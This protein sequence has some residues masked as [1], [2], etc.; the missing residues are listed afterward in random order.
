M[1][2]TIWLKSYLWFVLLLPK[3]LIIWLSNLS[4]L[5]VPD[6]GCSRNVSCTLNLTSTFLILFF[7]TFPLYWCVAAWD[8]WGNSI[9]GHMRLTYVSGNSITGQMW[10][11]YVRGSPITG[12]MWITYVWG[13][14]IT[15]HIWLTYVRGNPITCHMWLTYVRGNP[16]TGHI[17]LTY[18]MNSE[19]SA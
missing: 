14:P 10:L 16:I 9:T 11:T 7:L 4:I 19:N 15:G 8:I 13:N 17:W 2:N 18:V 12:R 5:S 1:L 6:N 3:T